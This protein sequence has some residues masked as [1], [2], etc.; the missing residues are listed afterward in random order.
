MAKFRFIF[1]QNALA[2][3]FFMVWLMFSL[4]FGESS[5][6]P[7]DDMADHWFVFKNEEEKNG[8]L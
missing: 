8:S 4:I 7:S 6:S 5:E 3:L 2:S 1:V